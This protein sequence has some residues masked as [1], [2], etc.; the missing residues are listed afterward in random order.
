MHPF[1]ASFRVVIRL[2]KGMKAKPNANA[3]TLRPDKC[4]V[5]MS[6]DSSLR[7]VRP[8]QHGIHRHHH[9]GFE[10]RERVRFWGVNVVFRCRGQGK[11]ECAI[12]R[13]RAAARC[14]TCAGRELRSDACRTPSRVLTLTLIGNSQDIRIVLSGTR[15][16]LTH[17]LRLRHS[18]EGHPKGWMSH[19]A[20]WP[21]MDVGGLS[22][23]ERQKS[24]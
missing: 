22:C 20:R 6:L 21:P 23:S 10:G 8:S 3:R 15:A 13:S 7:P 2:A 12:T 14:A 5:V 9:Q 17:V 19:P 4:L 1:P 11:S 16:A 24:R 18:F